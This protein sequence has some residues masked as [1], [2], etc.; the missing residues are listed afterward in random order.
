MQNNIAALI[1]RTY[2]DYKIK[3]LN[4]NVASNKTKLA[5]TGKKTNDLSNQFA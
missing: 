4:K 5:E 1:K 2:L 3:N